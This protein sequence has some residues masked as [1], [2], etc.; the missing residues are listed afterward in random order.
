MEAVDI[1]N[2]RLTGNFRLEPD[3]TEAS[4]QF[5]A[6]SHGKQLRFNR[7]YRVPGLGPKARARFKGLAKQAGHDYPIEIKPVVGF[8]WLWCCCCHCHL[9]PPDPKLY[10]AAA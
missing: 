5:L 9:L 10:T 4:P 7:D 3:R 2:G 1:F 8:T 6:A